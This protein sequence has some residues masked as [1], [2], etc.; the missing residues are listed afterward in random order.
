MYCKYSMKK[1][2]FSILLGNF[3]FTIRV[4]G[5]LT[6]HETENTNFFLVNYHCEIKGLSG[7]EMGNRNNSLTA[8]QDNSILVYALTLYAPWST[9]CLCGGNTQ[10][11]APE[12]RGAQVWIFGVLGLA[13]Q[14]PPPVQGKLTQHS[15]IVSIFLNKTA[16]HQALAFSSQHC[17][18]II[19]FRSRDAKKALTAIQNIAF[20]HFSLV[21]LN[22]ITSDA[23]KL[24]SFK[25]INP[26][27]N[28]EPQASNIRL[29]K[30]SFKPFQ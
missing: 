14:T 19:L 15:K 3:S 1:T 7:K 2:W 4:P 22:I 20:M 10:G 28:L 21:I 12:P 27:P 23:I 9:N 8:T 16:F 30:Q 24:L 5:S 13:L 26:A 18:V 29:L 6:N 25:W 11:D 17:S